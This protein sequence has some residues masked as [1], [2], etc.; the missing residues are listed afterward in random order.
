MSTDP[1]YKKEKERAK[2]EKKAA[3]KAKKESMMQDTSPP[4]VGAMEAGVAGG[5]THPNMAKPGV[6]T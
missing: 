5:W 3:K 6:L 4:G 1:N 2:K